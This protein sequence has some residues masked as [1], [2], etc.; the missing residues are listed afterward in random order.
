MQ[1]LPG[2]WAAYGLDGNGDGQADVWNLNDALAG[3]T[4]FLCEHG[5]THAATR[6][7]AI[8]KYNHSRAYVRRV[9][10]RTEQLHGATS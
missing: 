7:S 3:A 5:V 2:T 6:E 4:R 10:D 9:L 1:F 8:F